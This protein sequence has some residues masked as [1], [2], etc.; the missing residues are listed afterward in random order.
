[1]LLRGRPREHAL[2]LGESSGADAAAALDLLDAAVER[3]G[4]AWVVLEMTLPKRAAATRA[5]ELGKQ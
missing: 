2:D 1:M 5:T 4:R 3:P